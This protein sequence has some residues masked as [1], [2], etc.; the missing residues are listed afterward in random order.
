MLFFLANTKYWRKSTGKYFNILTLLP[1]SALLYGGWLSNEN[2]YRIFLW[3]YLSIIYFA[4]SNSLFFLLRFLASLTTQRDCMHQTLT[5]LRYFLWKQKIFQMVQS[6]LQIIQNCM[7]ISALL[8]R[9]VV[10]SSFTFQYQNFCTCLGWRIPPWRLCNIS[11][12]L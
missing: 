7:R 6:G 12:L 10:I 3:F 8:L 9:K 1:F 11:I 5:C 2:L 4:R